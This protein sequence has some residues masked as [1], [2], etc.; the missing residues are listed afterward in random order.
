MER[1]DEWGTP[2]PRL[3]RVE[4]FLTVDQ[5]IPFQQNLIGLD[6]AIVAMVARSNDISDLRPLV[7]KVLE[8]IAAS[9]PGT[10]VRVAAS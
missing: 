4:V 1:S 3:P 6:L 7:P 10:F 5:G 8:A 2:V 9:E